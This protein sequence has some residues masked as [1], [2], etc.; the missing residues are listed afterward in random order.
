MPAKP[1]SRGPSKTALRKQ[2]GTCGKAHKTHEKTTE[3]GDEKT[4]SGHF[5]SH[6]EKRFSDFAPAALQQASTCLWPSAAPMR[7]MRF[8]WFGLPLDPALQIAAGA[9]DPIYQFL[10]SIKFL[11][12]ARSL[13]RRSSAFS[14]TSAIDFV[15]NMAQSFQPAFHELR[16]SPKGLL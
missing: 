14:A 3:M 4:A 10:T 6:C 15:A 13:L 7:L 2:G 16:H 5:A 9:I 12:D 11:G 8:W 1:N